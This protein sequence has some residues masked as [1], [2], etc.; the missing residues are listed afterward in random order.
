MKGIMFAGFGI[1]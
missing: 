1:M